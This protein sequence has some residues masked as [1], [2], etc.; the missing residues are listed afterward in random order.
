MA[1]QNQ[2]VCSYN[3]YGFCKFGATC[4]KQHL[5]EKCL[6]KTCEIDKCSFRHPKVYRYF[7][8][9]G[10]CK[11]GE[12]CLF[13]HE[14]VVSKEIEDAMKAYD[15]KFEIFDNTLGILK[16][17]IFEKDNT[18]TRLQGQVKKLEQKIEDI[19]NLH[20]DKVKEL[21]QNRLKNWNKK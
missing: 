19:I 13:K 14:K 17:C 5:M 20:E 18:I 12:W 8:D 21:T 16:Q 9:I 15:A 7:R 4:R 10:Y 1:Q 3:K 6:N 11:F 2:N